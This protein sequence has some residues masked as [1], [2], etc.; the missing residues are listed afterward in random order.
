MRHPTK[1]RP[2]CVYAAKWFWRDRRGMSAV[3]FCLV[4]PLL[5]LLCF[6]CAAV[7]QGVIL[8]RK[9]TLIA[10]TVANLV[11]QNAS[12]N[13]TDM[14]NFFGASSLIVAPYP[15]TPV[16]IVL[17]SVAIDAS[18]NATVSWSKT[19]NGTARS[20]GSVVPLP[21][22]ISVKNTS[23]IMSEVTYLYKP[24]FSTT[25]IGTVNLSKTSYMSPRQSSSVTYT[26]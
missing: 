7:M 4:V 24:G 3:E 1:T 8:Q 18:G 5:I 11:A 13:S 15:T 20:T 26:S 2:G 25:V 23:L 22:A 9:V 19:S 17:T 12:V 6:G 21:A 16:K 14:S 10:S